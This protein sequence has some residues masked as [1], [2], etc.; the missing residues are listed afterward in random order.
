MMSDNENI[1]A[2]NASL[3]NRVAE[4][5]AENNR[6]KKLLKMDSSHFD[7][8]CFSRT[9]REEPKFLLNNIVNILAIY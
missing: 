1:I 8:G 6:L 2:E 9:K 7:M 5:E 3:K 4:L